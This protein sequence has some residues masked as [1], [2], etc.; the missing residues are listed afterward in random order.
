MKRRIQSKVVLGILLGSLLATVAGGHAAAQTP[1]EVDCAEQVLEAAEAQEDLAKLLALA[2]A[3]E[4]DTDAA[5]ANSGYIDELVAA[6]KIDPACQPQAAAAAALPATG[7][8]LSRLVALSLAAL[9]AGFAILIGVRRARM[10]M[11]D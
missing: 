3:G 5:D 1:A 10:G 4:I 8:D 6:T 7:A 2:E 9:L 11:S